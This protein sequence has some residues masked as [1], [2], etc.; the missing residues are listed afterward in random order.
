MGQTVLHS[1]ANDGFTDI[2]ELLLN[3]KADLRVDDLEVLC[4]PMRVLV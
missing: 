4:L 3:A 1:A 2:A